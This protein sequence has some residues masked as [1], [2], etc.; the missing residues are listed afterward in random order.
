MTRRQPVLARAANLILELPIEEHKVRYAK[1]L[2]ESLR[3]DPDTE[4]PVSVLNIHRRFSIDLRTQK[5]Y[6]IGVTRK[7]A[8]E[9]LLNLGRDNRWSSFDKLITREYSKKFGRDI[10]KA[11][12]PNLLTYSEVLHLVEYVVDVPMPSRLSRLIQ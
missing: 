7:I 2:R 5:K 12:K 3:V 6:L 1:A 10:P 11:G 8:F 4:Q 9:F